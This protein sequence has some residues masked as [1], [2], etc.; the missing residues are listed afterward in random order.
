MI[1]VISQSLELD[2]VN[3]NAYAKFYQNIPNGLR[4]IYIFH[5]QAGDKIFTN[6]PVTKSNVDYRAHNESQPSVSVDFP[7]MSI[8]N[9]LRG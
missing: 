2:V 1:N 9:E 5:E 6:C 7:S 8:S 4:V 3:I